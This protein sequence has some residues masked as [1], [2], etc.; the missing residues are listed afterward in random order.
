M[1]PFSALTTDE[2]R[3]MKAGLKEPG[4]Y[5]VVANPSSFEL[6]PEYRDSSM[7]EVDLAQALLQSSQA[8]AAGGSSRI[9][10]GSGIQD[11]EDPDTIIL[12]AFEEPVRRGSTQ[13]PTKPPTSPSPYVFTPIYPLSD[14]ARELLGPSASDLNNAR[15]GGK[16]AELLQHYRTAISHHMGERVEDEDV[17]ETQ[18]R[19]YPPVSRKLSSNG[20][21]LTPN[22]FSMR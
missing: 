13:L 7:P 20:M 5:F 19:N 14:H 4:K 15:V 18:A 3:E 16:D 1:P 10:S 17:F 12:K 8:R 6:L 21:V 9:P 2:Q 22:S 11:L